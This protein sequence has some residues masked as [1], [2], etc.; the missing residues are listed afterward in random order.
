MLAYF[1]GADRPQFCIVRVKSQKNTISLRS[2]FGNPLYIFFSAR[3]RPVDQ[4]NT[5]THQN[6]RQWRP[7]VILSWSRVQSISLSL[8]SQVDSFVSIYASQEDEELENNLYRKNFLNNSS[9]LTSQ[10]LTLSILLV[11]YSRSRKLDDLHGKV[12][13]GWNTSTATT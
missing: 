6:E 8:W 13:W 10:G 9:Y 7:V 5:G 1:A 3:G 11:N 4:V 2:A 12:V